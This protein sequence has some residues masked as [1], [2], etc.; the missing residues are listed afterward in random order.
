MGDQNSSKMA[1]DISR[2]AAW[3][4]LIIVK[5]KNGESKMMNAVMSLEFKTVAFKTT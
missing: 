2:L 1:Q 4:G 5:F 3:K